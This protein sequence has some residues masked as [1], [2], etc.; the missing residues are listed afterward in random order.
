[1][2]EVGLPQYRHGKLRCVCCQIQMY[3]FI[4]ANVHVEVG[5]DIAYLGFVLR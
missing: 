3:Y 4:V 5:S 1:M 2:E